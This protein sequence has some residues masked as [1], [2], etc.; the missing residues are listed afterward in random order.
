MRFI[1][2]LPFKTEYMGDQ[3][4]IGLWQSKKNVCEYYDPQNVTQFDS[5]GEC[6][7]SE[8]YYGTTDEREPQFC[9]RH[10][11]LKVVQGIYNLKP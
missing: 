9:A 6:D 3:L 1:K 5:A 2:T 11:Y 8:V 7:N 10:F 4:E